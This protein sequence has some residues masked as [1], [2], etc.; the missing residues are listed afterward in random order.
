MSESS[1]Q[2]RPGSGHGIARWIQVSS[3]VG[4]GAYL[5][6]IAFSGVGEGSAAERMNHIIFLD[7]F[8]HFLLF[9]I[10]P[11]GS[12][13]IRWQ[14]PPGWSLVWRLLGYGVAIA[15]FVYFFEHLAGWPLTLI[16]IWSILVYLTD[17]ESLRGG[18]I[19]RVVWAFVSAFLAALVGSI[20]GVDAE[21]LLTTHVPTMLGW[22]LL[23]FGGSAVYGLMK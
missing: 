8:G 22:G 4:I 21:A 19:F 11:A 3:Y 20:A 15:L 2:E 18:A 14:W 7:F 6:W 23:Y 5:A 10:I 1:R 17:V 16:W 12:E 13:S 9:L